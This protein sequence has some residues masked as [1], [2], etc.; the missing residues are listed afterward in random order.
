MFH[1]GGARLI[2]CGKS[3]EKLEE[4]ADDLAN[5]S[6]PTVVSRTNTDIRADSGDRWS[7]NV[8]H[9]IFRL[10]KAV[11]RVM[12]LKTLLLCL[13]SGSASFGGAFEGSSRCSP[14]MLLIFP[15]F[16]RC[17]ATVLRGLTYPKILCMPE[18]LE[19]RRENGDI[20]WCRSSLSRTWAAEIV[21]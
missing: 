3:W 4:F 12:N 1:K 10:L 20:V 19:R 14:Q 6:D 8:T 21:T 11:F 16:R 5:A 17:T 9:D 2:L 7:D 18:K 13:N 15:L